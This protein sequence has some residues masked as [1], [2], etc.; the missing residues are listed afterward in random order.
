MHLQ[1]KH[2]GEN[3]G[4]NRCAGQTS[5]T[6][7]VKPKN[8]ENVHCSSSLVE[9]V[10]TSKSADVPIPKVEVLSE[11]SENFPY[12]SNGKESIWF[13]KQQLTKIKEGN[14]VSADKLDQ[15]LK[16]VKN[17]ETEITSVKKE[18]NEN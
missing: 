11:K 10:K 1:Q 13:E 5:I 14:A 3:E 8:A 7:F 12:A 18:K 4:G 15:I 2:P 16:H 9:I 17:L 6:A